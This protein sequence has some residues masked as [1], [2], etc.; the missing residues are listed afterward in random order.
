MC[1]YVYMCMCVCVCTQYT[2][3]LCACLS[4]VATFDGPVQNGVNDGVN[5]FVHI[6]EEEWEAKF[7]GNLQVL[8]EVRVIESA[9]LQ[10][11]WGVWG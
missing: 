3:G 4:S 7:D 6:T 8:Q 1:V 9:H 5:V 10:C 11:E 2:E